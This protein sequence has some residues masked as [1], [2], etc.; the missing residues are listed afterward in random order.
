M[1]TYNSEKTIEASLR[2]IRQQ[3]YPQDRVEILIIDGGSTD[4]TLTIAKKYNVKILHNE[5]RLP[6]AAKFMGV[7]HAEGRYAVYLDSD[8]QFVNKNSLQLRMELFEYNTQIKNIVH[9]GM[10]N[11]V[12]SS[13]IAQ[14]SNY[15]SDPFSWFV[16]GFNGYDRTID[17]KRRFAYEELPHAYI[18]HFNNAGYIPIYDAAQHTFELN[19]IRA[20]CE[21]NTTPEDITANA[22]SSMVSQTHCAG[23]IKEDPTVHVPQMTINGYLRKLKWRVKGNVFIPQNV[24]GIG[25]S[26]RAKSSAILEKRKYLYV[27]YC[28]LFFL[29]II[30]SVRLSI[31]FRHPVFL[32]HVFFC[33]YVFIHIG[34]YMMRKLLRLIPQADT[35][36][37]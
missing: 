19:Y 12:E 16:Y 17:M 34:W 14:Y 23:M 3:D 26:T 7:K 11:A 1:P 31:K 15:L 2:S 13:A 8:E 37:G 21:K 29:P 28:L 4:A 22:F 27:L 32:L 35:Q 25:F 33:E 10:K 36:Y 5:K 9:S 20:L 30:D 24:G 6:E 18:F